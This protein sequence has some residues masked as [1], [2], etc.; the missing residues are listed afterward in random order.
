M[1]LLLLLKLGIEKGLLMRQLGKLL[2]RELSERIRSKTS[3][4]SGLLLLLLLLLV[5]SKCRLALLLLLQQRNLLS[6]KHGRWLR[7]CS[8]GLVR[9]VSC[10]CRLLR[11]VPLQEG[12]DFRLVQQRVKLESATSQPYS[13]SWPSRGSSAPTDAS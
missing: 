7:R 8:I 3:S 5:A 6:S 2:R 9:N 10:A 4:R 12:F 11:L 13:Q 1:L